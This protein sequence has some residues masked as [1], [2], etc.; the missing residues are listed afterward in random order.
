MD[1]DRLTGLRL[2]PLVDGQQ[3][4]IRITRPSPVKKR[5]T[6]ATA[7]TANIPPATGIHF[8]DLLRYDALVDKSL[9]VSEVAGVKS[10]LVNFN[11]P[12]G[13]GKTVNLTMLRHFFELQVDPNG[14]PIA[15]VET[16]AYKFFVNGT[17]QDGG[18]LDQ[19]F[20]VAADEELISE[21]LAQHPVIHLDFSHTGSY[22]FGHVAALVKWTLLKEFERHGHLLD[23]LDESAKAGTSTRV[24]R[25]QLEKYERILSGDIDA[26]S[27]P[28]VSAS[29]S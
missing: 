2:M 6:T 3:R 14:E 22:N 29:T 26:M 27:F 13:W 17:T 8:E 9:L 1:R 11:Y 21:H 7:S 23:W 15:P 24:S 18:G 10:C 19:H 5:R 20:A 4:V 28:S 12:P 25:F 16:P